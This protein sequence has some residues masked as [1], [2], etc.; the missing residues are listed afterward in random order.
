MLAIR[1]SRPNCSRRLHPIHASR[2]LHFSAAAGRVPDGLADLRRRAEIVVLVH[3]RAEARLLVR[4]HRR[5]GQV[6]EILCSPRF[7]FGQARSWTTSAGLF[8]R[9]SKS[10]AK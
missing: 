9:F 8:S 3:E 7:A 4:R 10:H 1:C 6:R 2:A 5:H